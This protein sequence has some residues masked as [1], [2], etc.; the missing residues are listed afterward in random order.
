MLHARVQGVWLSLFIYVSL[1]QWQFRADPWIRFTDSIACNLWIVEAADC[2]AELSQRNLEQTKVYNGR[3]RLINC[4]N[5]SLWF[6]IPI[7]WLASIASKLRRS[8]CSRQ[9]VAVETQFCESSL[10]TINR[11]WS[12]CSQDRIW[13]SF[14]DRE[15]QSV[16]RRQTTD[17]GNGESVQVTTT[18]APHLLF[19]FEPTE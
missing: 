7:L 5:I 11:P 6:S 8:M 4:S 12:K 19:H 17:D 3:K 16:D 1:G 9:S 13:I 18:L 14:R 15:M 10:A 2:T